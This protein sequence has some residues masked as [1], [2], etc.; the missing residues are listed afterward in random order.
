MY[1][2][3]FVTQLLAEERMKDAMR[4]NE[5][6]HLIREVEGFRKSW[7]WRL[8]MSLTPESI[9]L[10]IQSQRKQLR[11]YGVIRQNL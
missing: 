1:T 8:P 10:F 3:P 9:L 2:N 5:Q 6:T 11:E 7:R 4:R